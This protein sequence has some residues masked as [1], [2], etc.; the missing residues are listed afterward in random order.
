MLR[1]SFPLL[2]ASAAAYHLP[3][4]AVDVRGGRACTHMGLFDGVKDAFGSGKGDK[5]LVAAD[6][7]TPFDR[8]LGL[9]KELVA[10]EAPATGI[11]FVDPSDTKSYVTVDLAKPM[12]IAFVSNDGDCGGV[13]IDELLAEGSASSSAVSLTKGDQLVA[14]DS[15]L[16]LGADFDTAL[17]AIKSSAGDT[18]KLV[19]FRGP[20]TFLY[21]PTQP[22]VEWYTENLL[23]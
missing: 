16:L 11:T 4:A 8:W 14:C 10:A 5:P 22:T 3:L 13:Y 9:D 23:K 7:V 15:T 20:T 1:F 18:C 19:F 12:G 21:G 17:D 6:R 2:A